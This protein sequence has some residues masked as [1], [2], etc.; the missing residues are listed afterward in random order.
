MFSPAAE[1]PVKL[2][3]AAAFQPGLGVKG[4]YSGFDNQFST[5][6]N[7]C[8]TTSESG[9]A[10]PGAKYQ[11][12]TMCLAKKEVRMPTKKEH[13]FLLFCG[14]GAR[15]WQCS[16]DCNSLTF[17]QAILNIY[18]RLRSVIGYNLWTL[19]S[20]KKTFER[21]P[22]KINTPMR[23][24]TYL[25]ASFTGC[26]VIVPVSD[27]VLMEERREH[28]R[29]MDI[30]EAKPAAH[31]QAPTSYQKQEVHKAFT[32]HPAE[33]PAVRRSIC[34]ICGRI[35]KT[36]GTGVFH[37]IME[38]PLP[39]ATD[40]TQ[41][42]ARKLTDI[43]GFNFEQS[44]K[45]FIASNEICRKCL[46]TVC[47]LVKKE[48]E[49][50]ATKEDLVSSFFSTTSK[51]NKNQT[52]LGMAE[53]ATCPEY[54]HPF[55]NKPLP[56]PMAFLSGPKS[57][58]LPPAANLL[59]FYQ[60]R[61]AGGAE[62]KGSSSAPSSPPNR[63]TFNASECGSSDFASS[64]FVSVSP[65][66]DLR[67]QKAASRLEARMETDSGV[68]TDIASRSSY[69]PRGHDFDTRSFASSLSLN[70]SVFSVKS[71]G[72]CKAYEPLARY[73]EATDGEAGGAPEEVEGER[74]AEGEALLPPPT[75]DGEDGKDGDYSNTGSPRSNSTSSLASID[76]TNP[77]RPGTPEEEAKAKSEEEAAEEAELR[78]P[79][80]KRKRAI[81]TE[82]E[83]LQAGDSCKQ[84]KV[85]EKV[86]AVDGK[87]E[88]STSSSTT[89]ESN[90]QSQLDLSISDN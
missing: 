36:P 59:Q 17:K 84:L 70:S 82:S 14:L 11:I 87:G 2:E 89:S 71:K 26:L 51:F 42:I 29:Q 31:A 16:M 61:W 23:M 15:K 56:L 63:G 79:W 86:E 22:E 90:P 1:G 9:A 85:E 54:Q 30:E 81:E 40:R 88:D 19:T 66:T 33:E 48:E 6:A 78:K 75:G 27:I 45:K 38:E 76:S 28:I 68:S 24:R 43:L 12:K 37:R 3:Q 55:Y 41:V 74:V 10:D 57:G 67:A 39:G 35:E 73:K 72:Q 65:P 7:S 60:P 13:G 20:D 25:G 64:S 69:G 80:K 44:R 4:G 32:H 46:R 62:A 18:P 21:I 34:L 47:D 53:D 8:S 5:A 49:V 77:T 58:Y 50:K 52:H 83:I